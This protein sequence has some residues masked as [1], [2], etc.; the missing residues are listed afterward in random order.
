MSRSV[1][2]V[3]VGNTYRRDDGAGIAAARRLGTLPANVRVLVT[4]GDPTLLLDEWESADVVIVIDATRSRAAAGTI[5]RYNANAGPLPTVFFRSSTHAFGISEAIEL[6]RR[7]RRLPERVMLFGIEG[8]DFTVGE[9]LSPE[10]DAAVNEV[11][12]LVAIAAS[13]AAT[14]PVT[15]L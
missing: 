15:Y 14:S 1:L 12:T 5:R 9:G 10:V 13:D 7:L 6:A 11:S 2:I 3:G 4:N 8:R